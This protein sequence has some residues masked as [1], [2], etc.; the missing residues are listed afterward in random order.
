MSERPDGYS[1]TTSISLILFLI[2]G[3]GMMIVRDFT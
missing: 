1:R 2:V 3:I